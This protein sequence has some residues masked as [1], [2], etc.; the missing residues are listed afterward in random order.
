VTKKVALFADIPGLW[1]GATRFGTKRVDYSKLRREVA[2][3]DRQITYCAAW[4]TQRPGLDKFA[5][6]L[7]HIGYAANVVA[8]GTDIDKLIVNATHDALAI[9]H[10]DVVAIAASSGRYSGLAAELS[11]LNCGLEIWSFP[12]AC[13]L[14]ELRVDRRSLGDAVLLAS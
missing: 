12:V 3:E 7:K 11:A 13:S 4:L 9:G 14:D 10:V 1:W 5:A 6:A 2:G 8:Q